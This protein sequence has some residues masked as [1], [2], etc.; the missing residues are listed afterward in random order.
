VCVCPRL[1]FFCV[2]MNNC[3]FLFLILPWWINIFVAEWYIFYTQ[4]DVVGTLIGATNERWLWF[5]VNSEFD[6][7]LGDFSM[8]W[9]L[10]VWCHMRI[11]CWWHA[12]A[13]ACY[14]T[15]DQFKA[16]SECITHFKTA[17]SFCS[18]SSLP[19]WLPE[20]R[21]LEGHCGRCCSDWKLSNVNGQSGN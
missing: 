2:S 3:V 12:S 18:Q 10:L 17:P 7:S 21:S 9:T 16:S 19:Q 15:R 8:C 20:F 6:S 11:R 5:W 1:N 14:W 13:G 4:R